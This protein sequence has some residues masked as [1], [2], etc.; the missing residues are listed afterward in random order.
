MR[1]IGFDLALTTNHK[2]IIMDDRGRALTSVISLIT[3]A[4]DLEKL[5]ARAREGAAPD[6]CIGRKCHPQ[7]CTR[8]SVFTPPFGH[9]DANR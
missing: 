3:N 6:E 7:A 2:A 8:L 1:Y 5:F 9:R 4:A